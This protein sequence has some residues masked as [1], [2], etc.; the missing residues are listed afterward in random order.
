MT[1]EIIIITLAYCI[2]AG[3]IMLLVKGGHKYK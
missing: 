2:I 1:L 3:I